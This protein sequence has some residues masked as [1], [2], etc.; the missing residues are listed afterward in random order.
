MR[1]ILVVIV[2][3]ALMLGLVSCTMDN[4]VGA[5]LPPPQGAVS[6]T[7]TDGGYL[8]LQLPA[9]ASL[10]KT[11]PVTA[12]I[13][14]AAGGQLAFEHSEG[15]FSVKIVL[16][17]G[18]GAVAKDMDLTML[19]D[20]QVLAATFG[21]DGTQFLT[22]GE[23]YFEAHGLDLSSY[24]DPTALIRK[25]HLLYQNDTT[26]NWEPIEATGFS[27]DLSTGTVVCQKGVIRHFSRYGFGL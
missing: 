23:L 20:D 19:A 18:P 27:A 10:R 12:T 22:P 4:P 26:G 2:T 8:P 17:F 21:P 16:K 25:L 5:P 15:A 11:V 9:A 6:V 1:N 3:A 14:A 13:T 7:S 24:T